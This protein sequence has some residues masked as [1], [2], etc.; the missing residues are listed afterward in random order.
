MSGAGRLP[1]EGGL[2]VQACHRRALA[3]EARRPLTCAL[4][5]ALSRHHV[6]FL[7]QPEALE[8]TIKPFPFRHLRT[9]LVQP[10]LQIFTA[11][12]TTRQDMLPIGKH[13]SENMDRWSNNESGGAF[14]PNRPPMY[15]ARCTIIAATALQSFRA[16]DLPD[17]LQH[18]SLS[19][20]L[21]GARALSGP[22]E[23]CSPCR[24]KCKAE[25]RRS[26][27]SLCCVHAGAGLRQ[28][29]YCNQPVQ[30]CQHTLSST[31]E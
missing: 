8:W 4:L 21:L 17:S 9:Q 29:F 28:A 16:V 31:P 10:S 13:G 22:G 20:W 6:L 1:P 19:Q 5:P 12:V 23:R 2:Q 7:Q 25:W 14:L 11:G 15:I 3:P 18:L 26:H 30:L 27:L 24:L